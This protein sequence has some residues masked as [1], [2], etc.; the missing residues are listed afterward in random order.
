MSL[1]AVVLAGGTGSRMW[2]RSTPESPKQFQTI[3][4]DRPLLTLAVERGARIAEDRVWVVTDER[5]T[6]SVRGLAPQVDPRRLLA[7]P[8][9]RG[10]L[11]A[12]TLAAAAVHATDPEGL[13]VLLPSDH[14]CHD[15]PRLAEAIRML[16]RH[17]DTDSIGLVA[18]P[19]SVVRPAFGHVMP[20]P[21]LEASDVVQIARV[22]GYVEKPESA[23][24]LPD[25]PWHRNMGIVI[26]HARTLLEAAPPEVAQAA[27]RLV[28]GD[29][30]APGPWRSL[31]ADRIEDVVLPRSKSLIVACVDIDW[32]DVGTWPALFER[33]DAE[34][35][36]NLTD[37]PVTTAAS[38]GSVIVS[39]ASRVA[40]IGV[41]DL[42][43]VVTPEQVVVCDRQHADRIQAMLNAHDREPAQSRTGSTT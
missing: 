42:L 14:L 1:H 40:A 17:L 6:Q 19:T 26:G 21:V 15:E 41:H 31:I 37:G 38:T 34:P 25:G 18:T 22:V 12:V 7:E 3:F 28:A 4:A 8:A 43:V 9:P 20:G 39:T 24:E 10:T 16:T 36:G 35:S 33:A 23:D 32:I 29:A 5:Y 27:E 13:L 2:P 11:G 30:G